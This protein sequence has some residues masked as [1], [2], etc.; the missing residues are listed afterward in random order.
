MKSHEENELKL[1]EKQKVQ[2]SLQTKVRELKKL[3][4]IRNNRGNK[5]VDMGALNNNQSENSIDFS[6]VESMLI[7]KDSV[8]ESPKG[9]KSKD[10]LYID[11]RG[12]KKWVIPDAKI[13]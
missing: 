12:F 2:S 11:G 7:E 13:V 4:L 1:K 8:P 6:K 10:R 5:S 3:I 9:Q